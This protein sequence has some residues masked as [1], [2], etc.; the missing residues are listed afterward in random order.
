MVVY[1]I[2]IHINTVVGIPAV[3]GP[4]II[5]IVTRSSVAAFSSRMLSSVSTYQDP[6]WVSLQET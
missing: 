2:Y 1:I 4:T 6:D 5:N 3:G